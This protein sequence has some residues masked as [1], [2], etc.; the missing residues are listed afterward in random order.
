MR[1]LAPEGDVVGIVTAMATEAWPLI[2]DWRKNPHRTQRQPRVGPP[3]VFFES[4]DA[5]L[6][7]GGIGYQAGK[8]A[9]EAVV[10]YAKPEM[11]IATG[12]AGELKPEWTLGRTMVAAE[13]VDEATGRR[14]K[15][16]YGEGTVVSSREI[17][18][19]AKKRELASRFAADVV[20]MESAAVAEVAEVHGLPFLAVKAISDEMDFE[21]PPL[22][23]F[24][25]AQ[26]RFRGMRFGFW[27]AWHPQWWPVIARLKRRSDLAAE[28]LA[29]KL[30]E[31][32][33]VH[34]DGDAI[35][36]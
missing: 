24:V 31:V 19:A 13:V 10:E 26:G 11:L 32:I 7:C 20:D 30:Q 6:L 9:A 5:V 3:W 33:Q 21:L 23:R 8:R 25:D 2:R 36:R 29:E 18:R 16:A 1:A 15:A 27:A 12:L 35:R 4:A 22:Q 28:K 34:G 14:F 17:A